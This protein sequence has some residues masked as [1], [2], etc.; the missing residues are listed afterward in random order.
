MINID[1][2]THTTSSDGILSPIEVVRRAK[3][4]GVKYLA[5]T[6]H[7]TTSGL[8]EAI[9]EAKNSNLTLIPEIGRAH[10]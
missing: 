10:V 3:H 7:D 6:D 2:H 9:S 5:I 1:L 4:N 8:E